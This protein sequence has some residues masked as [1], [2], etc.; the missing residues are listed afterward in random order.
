MII[1]LRGTS[2]SGKST[3]VRKVMGHY[4]ARVGMP[5]VNRRMP[6]YYL[7]TPDQGSQLAVLGHYESA[8]GGCDT[9]S[10]WDFTINLVRS[11]H[12][13]GYDVLF[14]GLI[15]S[16]E[17]KRTLKLHTDGLPLKIVSLNTPIEECIESVLARRT[18]QWELRSAKAQA[19]G[20]PPIK[21]L[22]EFN[23][24]NTINKMDC[25]VKS[26]AKLKDAGVDVFWGNREECL[27][28]IL[29]ELLS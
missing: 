1:N 5:G 29:K 23:P 25:I 22:R 24:K 17:V 27:D 12:N 9:I 15:L 20:K 7:C 28:T 2:G 26:V 14:E 4:P 19:A 21:P 6:L 8:C 13:Q 16:G 11:L 10:G 18:E 3:I